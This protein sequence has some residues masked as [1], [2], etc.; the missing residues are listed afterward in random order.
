MHAGSCTAIN[1]RRNLPLDHAWRD[2][3]RY[4]VDHARSSQN[5]PAPRRTHAIRVEVGEY[6]YQH[7]DLHLHARGQ[8]TVNEKVMKETGING[9]CVLVYVPL[10]DTIDDIMMDWMHMCKCIYQDGFTPMMKGRGRPKV[11]IFLLIRSRI[12]K[13]Y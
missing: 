11:L 12:F 4:G 1:N 7:N 10:F 6:L 8:K 9:L 3:H 13:D 5:R 2:D